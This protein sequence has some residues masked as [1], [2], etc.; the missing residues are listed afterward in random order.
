MK[1]KLILIL[2]PVIVLVVI[3]LVVI[4]LYFWWYE[5]NTLYQA[6]P[7]VSRVSE[8]DWV[9]L[10]E[11]EEWIPGSVD[12]IESDRYYWKDW[13]R[14][15]NGTESESLYY[16]T[17]SSWDVFVKKAHAW[18]LKRYERDHSG[19]SGIFHTFNSVFCIVEQN[20]AGLQPQVEGIS[21]IVS[22]E[23]TS[24]VT[25]Y[26]SYLGE[27]SE[28]TVTYYYFVKIPEGLPIVEEIVI[29]PER[30]DR[31]NDIN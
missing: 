28:E 13:K 5:K 21:Q 29:R 9:T 3:A 1:K 14:L 30:V 8:A 18:E 12:V 19:G 26:V 24:K 4:A 31:G 11:G 7:P 22:E 20:N 2:I 15:L 10:T 25:L 6:E 27:A 16:A 17:K 23:G